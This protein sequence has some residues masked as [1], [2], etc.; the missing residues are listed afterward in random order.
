MVFIDYDPLLGQFLFSQSPKIGNLKSKWLIPIWIECL[1]GS[2]PEKL[3]YIRKYAQ[4]VLNLLDI[5]DTNSTRQVG[6]NRNR[7]VYYQISFRYK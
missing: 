3:Y 2:K 7:A 4:L 5:T 1:N 6:F